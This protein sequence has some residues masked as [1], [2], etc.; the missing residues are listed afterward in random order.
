MTKFD[1]VLA[2]GLDITPKRILDLAWQAAL[3]NWSHEH[4]RLHEDPE[5]ELAKARDLKAW[6]ELDAICRLVY[7]A[8]HAE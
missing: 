7:E 3:D 4:D 2:E 8:E 1:F 5:S 6:E